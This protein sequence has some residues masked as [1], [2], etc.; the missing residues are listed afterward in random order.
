MSPRATIAAATAGLSALLILLAGC[1]DSGSNEPIGVI[2]P[3]QV[4]V[5]QMAPHF[6]LSGPDEESI[7]LSDFRG[8]VV[9]LDF[10]ASWCTP[11]LRALPGLKRIWSEFESED[12]VILGVSQDF[13]ERDWK[14]FVASEPDIG[15]AHVYDELRSARDLYGINGIPH[16]FLID[17]DGVILSSKV[18]GT[19]ET[20]LRET[21][22]SIFGR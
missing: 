11:C 1:A 20:E 21:L 12:F 5:G 15:W 6:T 7:A 16:T 18:F 10:W 4:E 22:D 9:Y 3:I 2:T 13:T 19:G 17:R 8:K 14:T